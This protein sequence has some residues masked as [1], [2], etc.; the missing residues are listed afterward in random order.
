M[1]VIVFTVLAIV[2]N[3]MNNCVKQNDNK[4]REPKQIRSATSLSQ[5]DSGKATMSHKTAQ[6]WSRKED[7]KATILSNMIVPER[8]S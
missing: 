4:N 1:P 7:E 8:T 6:P 5:K 3:S 2:T